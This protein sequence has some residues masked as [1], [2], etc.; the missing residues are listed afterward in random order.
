MTSHLSY[1]LR[2]DVAVVTLDDG[3][4]NALSHGMLDELGEALDR[5]EKEAKAIALLGREGRFCAG[6]D[7]K[8]M[9][10]GPDAVTALM[11]KG[12]DLLLRLYGM[13]MPVVAA[14]TGHAL[15]GGALLLL[16]CDLRV[17]AEGPFKI[18][19]N[20]VQIGLP[21][22]L[23]GRELASDR[24]SKRHLTAATIMARIYDPTGACDA[25]YLDRAVPPAEVVD[26]AIAEA[27][28]LATLSRPAYA[29]T[30]AAFRQP[31]IARVREGFAADLAELTKLAPKD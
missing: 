9:M 6:F 22:P 23:L 8:T 18:G 3:K 27:K 17:G 7:L 28:R 4:A 19:L 29:A 13:P 31:T 15:A 1:A 26:T 10:A 21:L 25:G 24:L 12:G 5:A 2:D 20:E 30:K 11:T 14:C 16:T